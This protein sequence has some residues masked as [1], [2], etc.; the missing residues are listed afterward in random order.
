M[1]TINMHEHTFYRLVWYYGSKNEL[2]RF[3]GE[4]RDH[5]NATYKWLELR[6]A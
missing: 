1:K 5:S 3:Y 2:V 4:L 6:R